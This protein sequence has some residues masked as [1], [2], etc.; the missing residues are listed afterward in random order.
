M[1]TFNRKLNRLMLMRTLLRHSAYYEENRDVAALFQIANA[2][3]SQ[4]YH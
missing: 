4:Q 3:L 1:K 2:F